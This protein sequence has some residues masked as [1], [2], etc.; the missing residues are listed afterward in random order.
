[1][2][3]DDGERLTLERRPVSRRLV[4]ALIR[5]RRDDPGAPLPTRAL[6]EAG[7]PGDRSS[8]RA[9]ENRLWVA[10]SKLRRGGLE[11]VLVRNGNGY[12]ISPRVA[13]RTAET[14]AGT[15]AG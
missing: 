7:W 10:L 4:E 15:S 8:P 5:A 13:L 11:G 1:M 14:D 2:Q 9:L 3:V 12:L 6:V